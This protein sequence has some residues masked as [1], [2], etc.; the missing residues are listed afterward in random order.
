M[1]D[2]LEMTLSLSSSFTKCFP[3]KDLKWFFSS[4]SYR[5]LLSLW[6]EVNNKQAIHKFKKNEREREK[7]FSHQ[8]PRCQ[9]QYVAADN[10]WIWEKGEIEKERRK[11]REKELKKEMCENKKFAQ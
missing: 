10:E 1:S 7:F 2:P 3:I 6:E 4:F 9:I 8:K 11:K 5:Q